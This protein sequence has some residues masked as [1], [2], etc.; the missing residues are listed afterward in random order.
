MIIIL[1]LWFNYYIITACL[2]SS[3]WSLI[4]NELKVLATWVWLHCI[5]HIPIIIERNN[6]FLYLKRKSN[7][8]NMTS[9]SRQHFNRNSNTSFWTETDWIGLFIAQTSSGAWTCTIPI[10]RRDSMPRI[11]IVVL[12]TT[13]WRSWNKYKVNNL[14]KYKFYKSVYDCLRY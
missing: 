5:P 8:N 13:L 11:S 3:S 12:Q 7:L 10:E 14:V 6:Y 2:S 1:L 4:I 9:L